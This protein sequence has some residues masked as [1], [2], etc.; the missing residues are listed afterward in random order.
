[1]MRWHG[2]GVIAMAS[3]LTMPFGY[4]RSIDQDDQVLFLPTTSRVLGG[5][6]L[7]VTIDAWIYE[8]ERRPGLNRLLARYLDLDLDKITDAERALFYER[9]QLFR[10]DSQNARRLSVKFLDGESHR[11]QATESGGRINERVRI[12]TNPVQQANGWVE[13]S[14]E[15]EGGDERVF[16]GRSLIV[17]DQGLSIVSD[18][19]DT[20]KYSNVLKTKLLL[21]N[22]F[23]RPFLPVPFMAERYRALADADE[24]VRFHYI[25]SSPLQL[26]PAL[27]GF[28]REAEFPDGSVHLRESTSIRNV[29]P[30]HADS[31]AHKLKSIRRLLADF[32]ERRFLLIGDSGEL[33]PE[34]YGELARE[35]PRRI[36]GIRIR[37]VTGDPRDSARYEQAFARLPSELWE[38]FSDAPAWRGTSTP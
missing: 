33:D 38:L 11:L 35:F 20:I 3:M 1:M 16:K 36:E 32:P 5:G 6:Q 27:A 10:V 37:D 26:Y 18:I 28:L 14:A 19:D 12:E 23:A 30:G 22:T 4:A 21:I 25:S 31:R 17:A 29:V 34:I 24:D 15:L 9:T 7:E 8:Q 13:F 2:F